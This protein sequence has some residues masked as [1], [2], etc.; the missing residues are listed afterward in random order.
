MEKLIVLV[1]AGIAIA[2]GVKSIMTQRFD[3]SL[4]KYRETDRFGDETH[5]RKSFNVPLSGGIAVFFG[6]VEIVGALLFIV[7][8]GFSK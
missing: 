1:L 4:F 8:A 6:I 2:H 5:E 7:V 3:L